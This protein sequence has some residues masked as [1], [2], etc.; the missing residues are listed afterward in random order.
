ML[1]PGTLLSAPLGYR[2]TSKP[3]AFQTAY[4]MSVP[5]PAP[6]AGKTVNLFLD[7][8]DNGD[9]VPSLAWISQVPEPSSGALLLLGWI[10]AFQCR[11]TR[12]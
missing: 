12:R 6:F 2:D 10:I 8:F 4:S 3:W 7:L 9:A 1:D 5:V 11:R